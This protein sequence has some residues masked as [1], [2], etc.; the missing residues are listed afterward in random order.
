[1]PFIYRPRY[2]SMLK[3]VG[4]HINLDVNG[5]L[6][7]SLHSDCFSCFSSRMVSDMQSSSHFSLLFF[8]FHVRS[9]MSIAFDAG[10]ASNI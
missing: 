3:V 2:G 10:Q 5:V 6:L 8:H 7:T 1:M 9:L 4:L